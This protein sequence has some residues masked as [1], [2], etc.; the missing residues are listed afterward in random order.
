[1]EIRARGEGADDVPLDETNV[2]YQALDEVLT[3]TGR[4][5]GS[6]VLESENEIPLACGLG[7]SAAALLA[8]LAAGLLLSG[9]RLE[10]GRLIELGTGDE[11]HPDN[12]VPCVLGGFTVAVAAD[13]RVDFI[14]LE[15]PE[16]LRVLVAVP[17]FRVQTRQARAVLPDS[18]AFGDAVAN[19]GRVGLLAAGLSQGRLDLLRTA[20]EDRLHQPYRGVLVRGLEEVR[21]A[22][23]GAGALGAALSG[24]GPAMM[25]L[26]QQG[27]GKVGKAMQQ[28]WAAQ[29]ID[30]Q[31]LTLPVDRRGL[32]GRI[33]S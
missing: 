2:V 5:Q 26:V 7:S 4:G 10:P 16:S 3:R 12:I 24:A 30:A 11:G 9:E 22:A 25:A 29:G 28:A 27:D 13:G 23:L 20:M 17:N 19:L 6:L 21:Q 18:V 32:H 1:L 14:R 33:I 15:P 31:C 8:G